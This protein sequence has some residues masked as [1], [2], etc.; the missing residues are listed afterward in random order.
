MQAKPKVPIQ[1][2]RFERCGDFFEMVSHR[3]Y[4]T[5]RSANCASVRSLGPCSFRC[6]PRSFPSHPLVQQRMNWQDARRSFHRPA[7][8]V[9]ATTA[10]SPVAEE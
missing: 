6:I 4:T 7:S 8:I 1:M 2:M 3:D 5:R 9:C 10:S